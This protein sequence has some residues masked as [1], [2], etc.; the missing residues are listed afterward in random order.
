M[1]ARKGSINPRWAG[2]AHRH[3]PPSGDSPSNLGLHVVCILLDHVCLAELVAPSGHSQIAHHS[4]ERAEKRSAARWGGGST[5]ASA[6]RLRTLVDLSSQ[7]C[8]QRDHGDA[9][10]A[11]MWP[12]C[13]LPARSNCPGTVCGLFSGVMGGGSLSMPAS[14]LDACESQV[15]HSIRLAIPHFTWPSNNRTP[16]NQQICRDRAAAF[17]V[18]QG[19]PE[20]STS[21][22]PGVFTTTVFVLRLRDSLAHVIHTPASPAWAAAWASPRSHLPSGRTLH[23][24]DD[25]VSA[26]WVLMTVPNHQPFTVPNA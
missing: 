14:F 25:T 6:G 18:Q 7:D 9:P 21:R 1:Y 11:M 24:A 15:G 17:T 10:P 19:C 5:R 3:S 8:E 22:G 4:R 16:D 13:S 26:R 12:C 23:P 2:P 20:V